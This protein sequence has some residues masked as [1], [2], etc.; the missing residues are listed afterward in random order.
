[1]NL[2]WIKPC[3]IITKIMLKNIHSKI[4]AA[5]FLVAF[6][7]WLFKLHLICNHGNPLRHQSTTHQEQ[8][9]RRIICHSIIKCRHQLLPIYMYID[10][11]Y[12]YSLCLHIL[13]KPFVLTH[14]TQSSNHANWISLEHVTCNVCMIHAHL[15]T[16]WFYFYSFYQ[17]VE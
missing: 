16:G 10:C 11:E 7:Y 15:A 8:E 9:E 4:Y 12:M 5:T 1:M 3:Y 13:K 2:Y 17:T 6:W 14:W